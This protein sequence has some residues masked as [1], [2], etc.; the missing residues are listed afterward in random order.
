MNFNTTYVTV[1][2][3]SAIALSHFRSSFQYN[4]CYCQ[5]FVHILSTV[6]YDYFNTTYVTVSHG[7]TAAANFTLAIFQYNLCYCQSWRQF[8]Q[9]HTSHPISIQLMLL[10]VRSSSPSP[11]PSQ[12]ISI[13]LM[14]LLVWV[15]VPPGGDQRISIQLML[16]LV[17]SCVC[18][19]QIVKLFQYNLC[20]CQ[21]V[22]PHNS[23]RQVHISIQLMLLLVLVSGHA[24]C[25]YM[26]ISIQLMLLLVE[27]EPSHIHALYGFQYNLCYCQSQNQ[28]GKIGLPS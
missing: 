15:G 1:S 25:E 20:Y 4:L 10:L 23:A 28:Q 19:P 27:H 11:S 9:G 5:S 18:M 14:L 17:K 7:N 12:S 26:I 16:L 13:Q 3:R 22:Y 2:L 8:C 6:R 24:T 21:S